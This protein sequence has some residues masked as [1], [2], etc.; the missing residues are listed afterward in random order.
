MGQAIILAGGR[1]ERLRPMTQHLPKAMIPVIG[2]P[3]LAFQ[4]A[5]LSHWGFKRAL[6]SCG[7]LHEKIKSYFGSGENWQMQIEYI[8]ETEPLGRGGALKNCL[9]S[10]PDLTEPVLAING[11]LITNL[12]LHDF[13]AFHKKHKGTA[14]LAAVPLVSPYGI[15]DFLDDQTSVFKFKEKP[16]LPFWINAGIYML[17]PAIFDLLPDKGDHEESTFPQLAREGK[18]KAYKTNAFWRTVDTAKDLS[19]LRHE[20]EMLPLKNLWRSGL[21]DRFVSPA[22]VNSA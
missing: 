18:L 6:I 20:L 11:D 8:V 17:Q 13:I 3:I 10:M 15:V 4:L 1:G 22:F 5:W 12:D 14:S 16:T 21:N 19:E 9:R 2:T 7:Y